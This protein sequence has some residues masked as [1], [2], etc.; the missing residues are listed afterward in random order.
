MGIPLRELIERHAGGCARRLGQFAAIIPGGS[1]VPVLP[2][3]ICDTVLMAFDALATSSRVLP[4]PR[5]S[6]WTSRPTSIKAIARSRSSTSMKAA[7]MHAVPEG[8]GWMW[9]V[10]DAW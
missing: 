10:M 9:R 2:Q 7:A 8:A 1:S 5:S 4:P 6:S 3:S